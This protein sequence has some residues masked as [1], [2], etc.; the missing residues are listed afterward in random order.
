MVKM[1]PALDVNTGVSAI[2]NASSALPKM[3]TR[4]APYL[5]AIAPNKGCAAP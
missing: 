5:S 4:T 1:S 3:I 2:P